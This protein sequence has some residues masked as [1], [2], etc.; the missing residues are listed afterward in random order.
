MISSRVELYFMP[1]DAV[2]TNDLKRIGHFEFQNSL[3][4]KEN[5]FHAVRELKTVH[6]GA[7]TR[8]I[9]LQFYGPYLHKDNIFQQVGLISLRVIGEIIGGL[10]S[11]E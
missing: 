11:P 3:D 1:I 2:S 9:T 5:A 4:V 8:Q 7:T 10:P 6:F